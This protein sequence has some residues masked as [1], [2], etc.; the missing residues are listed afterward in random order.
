MQ[1]NI[2]YPKCVC[3]EGTWG[4][5]GGRYGTALSQSNCV[6]SACGCAGMHLTHPGGSLFL[7]PRSGRVIS[8]PDLEWLNNTMPTV[9]RAN[10]QR[11]EA[12]REAFLAPLRAHLAMPPFPWQSGKRGM[13]EEEHDRWCKVDEAL[14]LL[15]EYKRPAGFERSPLPPG[16]PF[17]L[18]A[19]IADYAGYCLQWVLVDH[20]RVAELPVP[21]DPVRV[22]HDARFAKLFAEVGRVLGAPLPER[23]LIKNG[24]CGD[25][26]TKTKPWYTFD[27]NGHKV[28]VGP[29]KHVDSIE[30]LSDA[31]F[32]DV[33]RAAI[34][35]LGTR[36]KVTYVA[37]ADRLLLH[38]W[39]D[40][41]TAEYL[42]EILKAVVDG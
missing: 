29:R 26:C 18:C 5:G 28:T 22:H 3:G 16:L 39:T 2:E 41:K 27:W 17:S 30:V 25:C 10:E 1:S 42:V 12:A 4:S 19:W 23:T 32:S 11:L 20:E 6:C 24:Y 13:T 33:A 35:E 38:A 8:D 40:K 9:W 36:D 14:K 34:S 21:A 37:D 7:V 15:R 31:G